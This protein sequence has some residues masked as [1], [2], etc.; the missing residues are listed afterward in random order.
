MPSGKI[1]TCSYTVDSNQTVAVRRHVPAFHCVVR[2][3]TGYCDAFPQK[4]RRRVARGFARMAADPRFYATQS[5]V[6]GSHPHHP[7]GFLPRLPCR[8]Q[9]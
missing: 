2:L 5:L 8:Y 4:H 1:Q 9:T 3:R 7:G 6:V